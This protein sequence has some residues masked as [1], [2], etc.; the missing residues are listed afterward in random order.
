MPAAGHDH[1]PLGPMSDL[2]QLISRQL[3]PETYTPEAGF[4]SL[5][6]KVLRVL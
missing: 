2:V 5:L 4:V 6:V 3:Q 1:A